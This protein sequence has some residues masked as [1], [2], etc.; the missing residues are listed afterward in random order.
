MADFKRVIITREGQKLMSDIIAGKKYL[1]FTR[2]I[3]SE[4]DVA[5]INDKATSGDNSA[6]E[7]IKL[8]YF[9]TINQETPELQVHAVESLAGMTNPSV[10][11]IASVDNTQLTKGYY[12]KTLGLCAEDNGGNEILYAYTYADQPGYMPPYNGKTTSG[13][14]FKI[15]VTVGNTDQVNLLQGSGYASSYEVNEIRQQLDDLQTIVGY[16]NGD[17]YGL[18]A[19]FENNQFTRL[20]GASN[21]TAGKDFDNIGPWKRKRCMIDYKTGN[22]V[23]Y[24]GDPNFSESGKL[25]KPVTV[26]GKTYADDIEYAVM[27]EQPKFYYRV[28][29]IKTTDNGNG[30]LSLDKARYYVSSTP[31]IGFKVHPAFVIEGKELDKIYLA[32]YLANTTMP[33]SGYITSKKGSNDSALSNYPDD[34]KKYLQNTQKLNSN[35]KLSSFMTYSMSLLLHVIESGTFN[36]KRRSG[37]NSYRGEEQFTQNTVYLFYRKYSLLNNKVTIYDENTSNIISTFIS[38]SKGY[39]SRFRYAEKDD[40][41]FYPIMNQGTNIEP[42]GAIYDYGLNIN[43]AYLTVDGLFSLKLQKGLGAVRLVL[44]IN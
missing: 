12:M 14:M 32:S 9:A 26:N 41:S 42:I 29:P 6:D 37:L 34:W 16:N 1:S 8:N 40:W 18:E 20:A 31:H 10:E 27:V 21:L 2:L 7:G 17:V 44:S 38:A 33:V 15:T 5:V 28:V 39:I 25:A 24:E 35:W 13:A 43:D 19:D 3:I 23:V 30:T 11:V 22:V 4:D 36:D